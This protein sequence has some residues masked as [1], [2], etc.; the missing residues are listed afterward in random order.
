[1][2]TELNAMKGVVE[3]IHGTAVADPYRWLEERHFPETEKWLAGQHARFESYFQRL[4]SLDGLRTQ[5]R[6]FVDVETI[7]QAGKVRDRYFY[8]RRK[9][10]EQQPSICMMDSQALA[11]KVLIDARGIE[12]YTHVGIFRISKGGTL[13]AYELKQGGE[14]SKAIHVLDP[15]TGKI[16]PDHLECGLSRGFAFRDAGDGFYFCHDFLENDP[17]NP[18]RDHLVR[19]HRFGT[20]PQDDTVLLRFPRTPSSKLVLCAEGEMLSAVF[21]HGRSGQLVVDF[22]TTSQTNHR[23]W[24]RIARGVRAPFSP[25]FC[26]GRLFARWQKDT[27]NGKIAELD[28][29]D[30]HPVRTIVPEWDSPLKRLTIAQGRIY[31]SYL[32]GTESVIRIWSLDGEFL[33][34][35]PLD[36][37][38]SWEIL[39]TYTDES[40]ELF[41]SCESFTRPPTLFC[42]RTATGERRV[43]SERHAPS[44]KS[45]ITF[46]K[47]EY[48]SKDG[49]VISMTLVGPAD[50]PPLT[51]R[52]VIMTAYGGFGLTLT[53]QFSTFVSVMLKM[54]FVFALPEIRGGEEHGTAWH[55]AARARNRQVAIND[56]IAAAEWLCAKGPTCPNKIAIFGGSNSGLLVGAAVTQRP[57]LF[58][59]ALC[60]APLLDMVRYHLFD[61]AHVWA[62]E[63]GTADD[64]DDFQALFAYSPYHNVA[65]AKNYPAV[66]FVSGD[67]DTRCNPA[68]ARKMTARLQDRTSQTSTILLDYS[69]QRGHAPTMPLA[70]RIEAL[71]NRIAFLCHELGVAI[72]QERCPVGLV[73][74]AFSC[75]LRTEWNLR[76]HNGRP[77]Q[78]AL[79]PPRHSNDESGRYSAQQICHAMDIACVLYF[80]TVLCL[81]RSV[82]LTML[83]RRFGLAAELVVGARILTAKAH[84]WV[85]I[86]R[87]VVNDKPY[88]TQLYRELERC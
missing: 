56:F 49:E 83:L 48:P 16:F 8:R 72:Q 24:N 11:E 71:T 52:P 2:S 79:E 19:F 51:D 59:A 32:V 22:H 7:D 60:I 75:L 34:Q 86:K 5:V 18:N 43:W 25:F 68:H 36:G 15:T 42:L 46:R 37:D 62:E 31:A 13:L 88:V 47:V 81:Q 87:V 29:T 84:A 66:L 12:T 9:V 74:L 70:V 73:S 35:L 63:Y 55:M 80:K 58:R 27:P 4:G 53:P 41:L 76:W 85:E 38:C 61:R 44:L 1:M 30:C 57:D 65:E 10:G 23:S 69:S 40:D 28:I 17:L 82:A 21:Y 78:D 20:S 33:G 67:K 45:P 77:L 6:A 26:R 14:H 39:S 50:T 54:G 64:P 3:R